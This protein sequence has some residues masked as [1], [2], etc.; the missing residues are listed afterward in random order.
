[1]RA[2]KWLFLITLALGSLSLPAQ[3]PTTPSGNV[4]ET[5]TVSASASPVTFTK[6]LTNSPKQAV[7]YVTGATSTG[8]LGIRVFTSGAYDTT[9]YTSGG[10]YNQVAGGN[11]VTARTTAA[12]TQMDFSGNANGTPVA[13][14]LNGWM[15]LSN[16]SALSVKLWNGFFTQADGTNNFV[17]YPAESFTQTTAITGFEIFS[18][19]NITG[20]F[21]CTVT[22]P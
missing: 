11:T 7:L 19:G 18:S 2:I 9:H 14:A 21:T 10:Y 8:T 15:V 3:K 17:V 5:Y 16:P 12:A 22:Q 4:S 20:T 6:C 13:V 1:M